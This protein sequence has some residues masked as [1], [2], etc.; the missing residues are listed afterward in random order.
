MFNVVLVE[1]EIPANTGNIGRTCVLTGARLH[2]V[3]PLGFSLDSSARKRAGLLYWSHVDLR[4]HDSWNSFLNNEFGIK[5]VASEE[6]TPEIS[7]KLHF[8]T[9]K[10]RKTYAQAKYMHGDYLIFGKESTGLPEN[11]LKS[12]PECCERIPMLNDASCGLNSDNCG[13]VSTAGSSESS[14]EGSSEFEGCFDTANSFDLK[15]QQQQQQQ[16]NTASTSSAAI[17][18]DICGNFVN[19]Q[20]YRVNAL[21]LSNSVAIMLYE[22]LRQTGFDNMD[23]Q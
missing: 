4:I 2:L 6:F 18:T 3:R 22:A 5:N 7:R 10:A 9:K 12:L 21:N 11:L 15:Q 1:P 23:A 17:K 13:G 8:A 14:S 20:D 19:V 16:P